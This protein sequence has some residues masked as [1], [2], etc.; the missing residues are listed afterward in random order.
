MESVTHFCEFWRSG[1]SPQTFGFA[2]TDLPGPAHKLGTADPASSR[3]A[4]AAP[5]EERQERGSGRELQESA[6]LGDEADLHRGHAQHLVGSDLELALVELVVRRHQHPGF[7]LRI[8]VVAGQVRQWIHDRVDIGRVH[9]D[10]AAAWIR[11][12]SPELAA[13]DFDVCPIDATITV[14]M[15]PSPLV[16]G[17]RPFAPTQ[18]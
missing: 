14:R 11:R 7:H 16:C 2:P 15:V 13:Q 18:Y 6:R 10:G 4:T 5:S 9:G 17:N 1:D 12:N 8:D 3:A